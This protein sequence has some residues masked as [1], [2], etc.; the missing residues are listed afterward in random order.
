MAIPLPP[1]C[2][3]W[4]SASLICRQFSCYGDIHSIRVIHSTRKIFSLGLDPLRRSFVGIRF[5]WQIELVPK[6]H[7]QADLLPFPGFGV[8]RYASSLGRGMHADRSVAAPKISL[9]MVARLCISVGA[10][11]LIGAAGSTKR[12]ICSTFEPS[13]SSS[14]HPLRNYPPK[15]RSSN[16]RVMGASCRM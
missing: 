3:K 15:C 12:R 13:L 8:R 7:H 1:G 6:S 14:H 5:P 4:V 16:S 9:S 10:L 11:S 2:M